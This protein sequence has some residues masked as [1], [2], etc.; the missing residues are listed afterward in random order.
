MWQLG[1]QKFGLPRTRSSVVIEEISTVWNRDKA[2]EEEGEQLKVPE[3]LPPP[4]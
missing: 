3:I 2:G 4:G 1:A